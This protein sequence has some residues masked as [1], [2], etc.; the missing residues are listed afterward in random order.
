MT[1]RY[2]NVLKSPRVSVHVSLPVCAYLCDESSRHL[3]FECMDV[4]GLPLNDHYFRISSLLF[5][6]EFQNS[7]QFYYFNGKYYFFLTKL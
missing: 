1:Y 4:R 6:S 5:L 2:T 3:A 7:S